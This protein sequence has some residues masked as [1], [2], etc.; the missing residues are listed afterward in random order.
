LRRLMMAQDTGN[1]IRSPVR[2]DFFWGFGH[3]ALALAGRMRSQ[4]SYY[5]FLPRIVAGRLKNV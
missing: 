1:A 5:L 3:S 4:G 2:G